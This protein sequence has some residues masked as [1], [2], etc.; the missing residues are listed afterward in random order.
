[1]EQ[2]GMIKDL[3]LKYQIGEI[4]LKNLITFLLSISQE[5]TCINP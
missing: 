2:I 4:Q 5:K 3:L 1:M